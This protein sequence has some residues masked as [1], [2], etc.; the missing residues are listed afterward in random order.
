MSKTIIVSAI[1]VIVTGCGPQVDDDGHE[2]LGELAYEHPASAFYRL[3]RRVEV[4][5]LDPTVSRHDCGYLSD[6]AYEDIAIT[7]AALDPEVD[8]GGWAGCTQNPELE[9]KVYLEGF[10]HSPFLCDWDCCHPDL[11]RVALAYFLVEN[12]FHDVELI[13]DDDDE[14]YVALEP[15]RP[16]E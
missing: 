15:D 7:V 4:I 13:V 3:D 5:P 16:C 12:A 6:R 9:G 2:P 11:G 1:A 14:P 10:E 8:Y